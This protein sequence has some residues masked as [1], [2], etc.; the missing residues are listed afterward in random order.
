MEFRPPSLHAGEEVAVPALQAQG[1]EDKPGPCTY[2][3]PHRAPCSWAETLLWIF[4]VAPL[5]VAPRRA[6]QANTVRFRAFYMD[7]SKELLSVCEDD[8]VPCS[9]Q[10][11]PLHCCSRDAEAGWIQQLPN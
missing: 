9:S 3:E 6:S 2:R 4:P 8:S 7:K 11:A 5:C 1:G 10:Q